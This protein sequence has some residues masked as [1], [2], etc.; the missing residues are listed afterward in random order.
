MYRWTKPS[1][2]CILFATQCIYPQTL[3][4]SLPGP[5]IDITVGFG[6]AEVNQEPDPC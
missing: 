5:E 4:S 3:V 6:L 2:A 1:T